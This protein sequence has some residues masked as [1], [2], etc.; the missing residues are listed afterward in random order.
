MPEICSVCDKFVN[1]FM[2]SKGKP[3]CTECSDVAVDELGIGCDV[4]GRHVCW[5]A[6]KVFYCVRCFKEK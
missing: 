3:V 2:T 1:E 6:G 4:C 5:K